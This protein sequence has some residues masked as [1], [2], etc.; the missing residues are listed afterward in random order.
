MPAYWTWLPISTAVCQQVRAGRS[1]T[2]GVV[3]DF[4]CSVEHRG[5][6]S[7]RA[8]AGVGI[9]QVGHP[10]LDVFPGAQR[11]FRSGTGC[12]IGLSVNYVHLP[13]VMC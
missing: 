10:G 11:I 12:H 1:C 7:Y 13:Q 2:Q 4:G 8:A 3:C 6:R 9:V 5:P